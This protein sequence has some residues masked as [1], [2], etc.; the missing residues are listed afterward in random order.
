MWKGTQLEP[1]QETE[2]I[3]VKKHCLMPS[4]LNHSTLEFRDFSKRV[5]AVELYWIDVFL[6]AD[7]ESPHMT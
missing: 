7:S 5:P 3:K 6:N 1:I 2:E 4:V